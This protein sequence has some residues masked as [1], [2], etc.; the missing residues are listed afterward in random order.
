M[1]YPKA[2]LPGDVGADMAGEGWYSGDTHV[3]FLSPHSA[4]LEARGEDLNVVNV[5]AAKWGAALSQ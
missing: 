5:L 3:R 4:W 2:L 1:N